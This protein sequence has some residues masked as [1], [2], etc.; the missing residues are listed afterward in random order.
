M[1]YEAQ[2]LKLE[3]M[4]ERRRNEL[5]TKTSSTTNKKEEKFR[6]KLAEVEAQIVLATPDL[7][8]RI[9]DARGKVNKYQSYWLW[10][11][12]TN[13]LQIGS[14]NYQVIVLVLHYVMTAGDF[15]FRL[16]FFVVDTVCQTAN[17]LLDIFQFK[18]V[19]KCSRIRLI[20]S[21]TVQGKL[22]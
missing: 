5:T 13:Q 3:I 17:L 15:K 4:R 14:D 8:L 6:K 12:Y 11:N 21:C 19:L 16:H 1:K 2:S 7:S 9:Y 20:R 10:T 18:K 22:G